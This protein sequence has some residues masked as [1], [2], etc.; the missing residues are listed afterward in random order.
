MIIEACVENL[1]EAITAEKQG[2]TQIELCDQLRDDGLTP[3]INLTQEAKNKLSIP[4]HVMI[5]PRKG[6][7]IYTNAEI[8]QMKISINKCKAIGVKG[9]VFG[10]LTS[11][12]EIDFNQT[13]ELAILASPLEVTFHK[14][15]DKVD[16]ILS[17]TK[18]LNG[19]PEITSILTSGGHKTAFE[20][21]DKLKKMIKI[22]HN[23]QIK[24]AG[25]ITPQN[26][27]EIQ[28]K[29]TAIAFHG[30]RIVG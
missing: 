10:I 6:N 16:D 27:K 17:A 8:A 19:I 1:K 2:A 24:V 13:K 23:T 11:E 14:A 25:K 7:F 15:I 29:S 9:V 21:V 5:R 12:N 28:R 18:L 4:I 30:R 20:G 3:D 26:I 22:S